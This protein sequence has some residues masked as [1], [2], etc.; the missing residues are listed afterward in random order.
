MRRLRLCSPLRK[1]KADACVRERGGRMGRLYSPWVRL[2]SMGRH[3][4]VVIREG[5]VAETRGKKT[6][7]RRTEAR[8]HTQRNGVQ[9]LKKTRVKTREREQGRVWRPSRR[10]TAGPAKRNAVL[11]APRCGRGR[12]ADRKAT[13]DA[14]TFI[15]GE[16]TDMRRRS[17]GCPAKHVSWCVCFCLFVCENAFR[18]LHLPSQRCIFPYCLTPLLEGSRRF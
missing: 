5:C 16:G 6:P 10:H 8:L 9:Q 13:N 11:K 2:N 14:R 12:G 17:Q 18:H 4:C 1:R 15:N 3:A 7:T